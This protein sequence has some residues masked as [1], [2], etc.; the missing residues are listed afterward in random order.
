MAPTLIHCD[1][2]EFQ[3]L[4]TTSFNAGGTRPYS[5]VTNASV[6]TSIKKTGAASV[7]LDAS[8]A[9]A[10]LERTAIITRTYVASFYIYFVTALP[11]A[12]AHVAQLL[13]PTSSTTAPRLYFNQATSKIGMRFGT[14]DAIVD[15]GPVL[16]AN[17]WYLVDWYV[18]ISASPFTQKLSI[19]EAASV[20]HTKGGTVIDSTLGSLNL[21][22]GAVSVANADDW[23]YSYTLA[24]YPIGPHFVPRLT[25]TADGTHNAGTN[26]IEDQAGADIGVVTAFNLIDEVV[27]ENTDYIKQSIIGTG[28]YAEVTF[29]DPGGV[30]DEIWLVT[31]WGAIEGA[32]A[33]GASDMTLRTV[34]GSSNTLTDLGGTGSVSNT[35]RRSATAAVAVPSGGVW[36]TAKL[37]GVKGRVGF[38]GDV[39]PVPRAL[40]FLLQYAATTR[41][42]WDSAG[43]MIGA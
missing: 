28:N 31:M 13:G 2:F 33:T 30:N 42:Y 7:K 37:Q 43:D 18:D 35:T 8:S 15:S 27:P 10:T 22:S 20:T 38:A 25:P 40:T 19:D 11:T 9:T 12:S 3:L 32:A 24:D 23:V 5:T 26:T 29:A 16:V 1:G 14:S 21:G 39:T 36:T 6:D 4:S 41:I 17:T 34:D